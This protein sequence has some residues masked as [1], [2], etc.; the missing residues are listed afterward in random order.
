MV[1][2]INL[3]VKQAALRPVLFMAL[4]QKHPTFYGQ[5]PYMQAATRKLDLGIMA[6]KLDTIKEWTSA[7]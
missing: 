3:Q 1:L 7:Q 4:E 2:G 6:I 5:E